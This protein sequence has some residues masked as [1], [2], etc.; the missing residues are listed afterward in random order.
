MLAFPGFI[1]CKKGPANSPSSQT[2]SS[3]MSR[4]VLPKNNLSEKFSRLPLK[5]RASLSASPVFA[6]SP[7]FTLPT[8]KT[9][10]PSNIFVITPPCPS[11]SRGGVLCSSII[12]CSSECY[13]KPL[14]F[15]HFDWQIC[16]PLAALSITLP[17]SSLKQRTKSGS[18]CYNWC[19]YDS[20]LLSAYFLLIAPWLHTIALHDMWQDV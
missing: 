3:H 7:N 2:V 19:R 15:N 6:S 16:W 17:L 8:D 18:C 10:C 20:V 12:S 14:Q 9:I 13:P 4:W 1:A 11:Q 5:C